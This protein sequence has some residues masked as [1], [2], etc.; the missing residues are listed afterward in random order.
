MMLA[1][2]TRSSLRRNRYDV[3]SQAFWV[4]AMGESGDMEKTI[5]RNRYDVCYICYMCLQW[6]KVE[7]R[8]REIG[9]MWAV[10]V[11]C[12]CNGGK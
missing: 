2:R 5:K 12:A 6:G 9:T 8:I 10:Y 7:I 11:I 1:S 4:P 3:R